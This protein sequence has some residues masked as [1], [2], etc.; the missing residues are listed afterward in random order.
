MSNWPLLSL[1]IWLPI[2]GGFLVL[3]LGNGRANAAR[4]LA[5]AISLVAIALSVPLFTGFD[6]AN[7][8]LQFIEHRLQILGRRDQRCGPCTVMALEQAQH[9]A[10][11]RGLSGGRQGLERLE[12]RAVEAP[13]HIDEV[14]CRL[15]D[16]VRLRHDRTLTPSSPNSTAP[17]RTARWR[18]QRRPLPP[19][20][21]LPC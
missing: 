19:H 7:A 14:R 5:L 8:G 3:A 17:A 13:E 16:A 2:V 12:G 20:R 10:L 15:P 21:S 6:H 18:P 11:E 9:V 4:W 1:L